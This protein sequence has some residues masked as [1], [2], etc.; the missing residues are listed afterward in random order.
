L[1]ADDVSYEDFRNAFV[2]RF[3]DKHTDH[4]HYARVQNASQEKNESPEVFL[5]RLRKLCQRTIRSSDNPVEQA[6]I[7][8]EAERRLLAA[9]INGLIGEPGKHVRLQMPSNLDKALN[10]AMIATNA[11]K[12]EKASVREDRGINYRVFAVGGNRGEEAP[13]NRARNSMGYRY[14]NPWGKFQCSSNRGAVFQPR[15]GPVQHSSGVNGTYPRRTDNRTSMDQ[16]THARTIE[17]GAKSGL[18]NDDDRCAPRPRGIRCYSCGLLGHL[19]SECPRGQTRG[20]NGIGRTKA[21]P[22][23]YPK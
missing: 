9:F 19:R 12:E 5:D 14:E 10:M 1:K 2:G 11:E 13:G 16:E 6:V 17:G 22:P 3:K 7:N 4:Y 18:K 23:S 20:L 8:Q 15:A 21:T